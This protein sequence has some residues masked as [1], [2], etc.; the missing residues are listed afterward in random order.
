MNSFKTPK[1][2]FINKMGTI[3][4]TLMYST[5]EQSILVDIQTTLLFIF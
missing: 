4:G 1:E 3:S 5:S 2:L